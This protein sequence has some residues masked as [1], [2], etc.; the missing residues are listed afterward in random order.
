M[1]FDLSSHWLL[2]FQDAPTPGGVAPSGE[3][4]AL[5]GHVEE[6][7]VRLANH[8]RPSS[9]AVDFGRASRGYK[10]RSYIERLH[11]EFPFVN[12]IVGTSALLTKPQVCAR[13]GTSPRHLETLVKA[14]RFP[15]PVRL[16]KHVY[17]SE[18]ALTSW[19]TRTFGPQETWIPTESLGS[20][21]RDPRVDVSRGARPP[22]VRRK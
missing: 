6:K 10:S 1:T 13:L 4:R 7:L 14:G 21:P 5:S 16:G 2:Q 8:S 15:P 20:S 3:K 11:L 9:E 17:W 12:A 18:V 19:L 22:P